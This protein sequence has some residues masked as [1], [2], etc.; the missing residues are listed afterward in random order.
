MTAPG[1]HHRPSPSRTPRPHGADDRPPRGSGAPSPYGADDRP[2]HGPDGRAARGGDEGRGAGTRRPGGTG[3]DGSAAPSAAGRDGAVL[4]TAVAACPSQAAFVRRRVAAYL[5]CLGADPGRRDD[6]VLAADELFANA[7]RHGGAGP[8]D[9]VTVVVERTGD[10]LR[11][12]VADRSPLLPC[13][14]RADAADERGRGL[15]IV[16]ALADDWGIS[17]PETGG[18]G[19]RVWFTLGLREP[20][21]DAAAGARAEE[22]PGRPAAPGPARAAADAWGPSPGTPYGAL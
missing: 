19:K 10:A 6:A 1:A 18:T 5:T 17:P 21:R 4:R 22:E 3:P 13:P 9:T 12:T 8:D 16:A 20:G 14:R 7:V 15:A 2:P 11:V